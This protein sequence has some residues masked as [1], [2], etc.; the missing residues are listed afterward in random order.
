MAGL[1]EGVIIDVPRW[2]IP[3]HVQH[4]LVTQPELAVSI[5]FSTDD[6]K[7]MPNEQFLVFEKVFEPLFTAEFRQMSK[8]W[9]NLTQIEIDKFENEMKKQFPIDPTTNKLRANADENVKHRVETL[10]AQMNAKLQRL[11]LKWQEIAGR[12]AEAAYKKAYEASIVAMKG[13][14]TKAK[15]KIAVKVAF[16]VLLTL[17]AAALSIFLGVATIP[18]GV[19][20]GGVVLAA[21][22]TGVDAIKKSVS[23]VI[24]NYDA[25]GKAM[26][27][28]EKDTLK[29]KEANDAILKAKRKTAGTFDQIKAFT[30]YMSAD[31][32]SL[33]KHVT[34][35]DKFIAVTQDKSLTLCKE[36][37]ELADK[38]ASA[39]KDSA[40]AEKLEK[41]ALSTQ[42]SIEDLIQVLHQVKI[43]KRAAAEAVE[44]AKKYDNEETFKQMPKIRVAINAIKKAS[45]L[46]KK[47]SGPISEIVSGIKTLTTAKA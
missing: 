18:A 9:F 33:N 36:L 45:E 17:T 21:M 2:Q 37:R 27:A 41:K 11:C 43:V 35:L 31:L 40:E 32:N 26:T 16:V 3:V 10:V 12:I 23:E 20:I 5:K 14:I 28:I 24:K 30:S 13:K 39:K 25:M 15:A 4:N 1:R 29:I 6:V 7:E 34:E 44:A 22:M 46:G 8:D 19:A 38:L 42:R 47:I